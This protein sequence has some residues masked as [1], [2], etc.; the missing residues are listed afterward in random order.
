MERLNGGYDWS[1]SVGLVHL[2]NS[3]LD[4]NT[5][6]VLLV[7]TRAESK[8]A[9]NIN[10]PGSFHAI[11]KAFI[12]VLRLVLIQHRTDFSVIFDRILNNLTSHMRSINTALLQFF[13]SCTHV[14]SY[15]PVG[16]KG[17]ERIGVKLFRVKSSVPFSN[18]SRTLKLHSWRR[19]WSE[20]LVIQLYNSTIS[21]RNKS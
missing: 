13:S 15:H 5:M 2:H 16:R 21:T 4:A 17:R 7:L 10:K 9:E 1:E 20:T 11:G 12:E 8:F 14:H 3:G 6:K 19:R 18:N